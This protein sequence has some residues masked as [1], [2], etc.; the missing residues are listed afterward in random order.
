[1]QYAREIYQKKFHVRV[2]KPLIN[3]TTLLPQRRKSTYRS[4]FPTPTQSIE[5]AMM[6]QGQQ[7]PSRPWSKEVS[8]LL[9]L[10]TMVL[11]VSSGTVMGSFYECK[12]SSGAA[13][14]TY[15]HF[16]AFVF[17]VVCSITAAILEAAAFYLQFL[18]SLTNAAANQDNQTENA[19]EENHGSGATRIMLVVLD[20]LVPVLLCSAMGAAYLAGKMYPD[21]IGACVVFARNVELAKILLVA[22]CGA[23]TLAGV[24]KDVPL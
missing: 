6:M 15:T 3:S 17:F 14:F 4:L 20:L 19:E 5:I 9:R 24:A 18:L 12:P 11:A 16:G 2:P 10:C 13:A 21:Q 7:G 22:A 23:I 1:M 8:L